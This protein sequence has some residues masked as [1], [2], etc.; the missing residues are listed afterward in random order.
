MSNKIGR[1]EIVSELAHAAIISVYKATDTESG[2][3]VA[4]KA[5][6][7][8]P[9]GEQ[10]PE[11]VKRILEE[12]E[13]C[14]V[15]N[16]HNIAVMHSA[17]EM[18]G[19]L[20]VAMEYVQGNGIATMLARKEG[21]SIWDLQD[22]ARQSCQGLDHAHVRKVVH[23]SLEPAKIMVQWDGIVKILS[24]GASGV[25]AFVT[26]ASGKTPAVLH[27]MS[28]EQLRGDP[29][30]ARS[31]LFSLGAIFYEMVTERKAF[32][33]EDPA[34]VREAILE[35][36]PTAVDQINR[37]IHPALSAVI[38]KALAKA[39]EERYQSGQELVNDLEKCKENP[40]KTTLATPGVAVKSETKVAPKP[41]VPAKVA[42]PAARVAAPAVPA[43]VPQQEADT[44]PPAATKAAAAGAGWGGA[45]AISPGA[46]SARTLKLDPTAQFISNCVKATVEAA[47]DQEARMSAATLEEPQVE[48]PK[49]AFDPMMD[50]GRQTSAKPRSFSEIDELP[51]LKEVYIAPEPAP[52]AAEMEP[53][54]VEPVKTS[55][56]RT[57]RAPKPRIPVSDVAKKAANEIKGTPPKLFLYA[58]GGAVVVILLIV[59]GITYHI[60]SEDADDDNT[61]ARSAPAATPAPAAAASSPSPAV[62]HPTAPAQVTPEPP[63]ETA[64]EVSITP[65]YGK[66]NNK[67]KKTPPLAAPAIISGGLS[68]DST[69]QGA[70]IQVDGQDTRSVT[71]FS[72]TWLPPGQHPIVITK[73]GYASETRTIDVL[74]GSRSM[75]S[76]QLGILSATV[77]ANSDPA[78]AAVWIDGKNTGKVTPAQIPIEKAGNHTFVF[79][80]Q[81]YLD[82]TTTA[83]L[84]IGQTSHL[85]ATL[86][87]LG[88]TDEIKIGHKFGKL[89]GGSDTAGMGTV[90][91]KTQPKGAQIAIN[92]RILDKMSPV[93]FYL[94]PG[95]YEVDITLSG[96]KGVHKVITVEKN[97]KVSVEENL[98]RE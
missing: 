47:T 66:A 27:Y 67:K 44:E 35:R 50:E 34:Q 1:F 53:E 96:F 39:P 41:V 75:I 37:K 23:Y 58:I 2:Q 15:L 73:P 71:P 60:H 30:D 87:P 79:K 16:S 38:M 20:C 91:V 21:F 24:F 62:V 22:I 95:N 57:V 70:Q 68:V 94:N 83:N 59:A 28:P 76:V 88:N 40:A 14:K 69:P 25:G 49:I 89:F 18:D 26:P 46:N 84:Q 7:L 11:M 56:I 80:K 77:S 54:P 36:T 72:L 86:R 51:P 98:D 61:P 82:E 85:T 31:N 32:E 6:R 93:E 90:S 65:K 19:Q 52:P 9:L 97:G 17:A 13:A 12:A 78:G 45:D 63:V 48:A 29:V 3:T 74:S 64:P 43:P 4:L 92:N 42:P 81:G 33:G 5:I 55:A 8:E 10:A